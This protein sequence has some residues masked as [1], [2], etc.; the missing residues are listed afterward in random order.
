VRQVLRRLARNLEDSLR[1]AT[2]SEKGEG[3]RVVSAWL[4]WSRNNPASARV[5][6]VPSSAANSVSTLTLSHCLQNWTA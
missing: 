3:F 2:L 1:E 5:R 6:S 4:I